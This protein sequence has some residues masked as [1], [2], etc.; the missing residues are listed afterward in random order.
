MLSVIIVED[1]PN[2]ANLISKLIDWPSM[3]ME[4]VAMCQ[5][6]IQA[7]DRIQ[8]LEPDIVITDIRMAG[9]DGIELIRE[10]R[11][12]NIPCDFIIISGYS[13]FDYA[14]SAIR[15]NVEDYLLKPINKGELTA[16]LQ[17]I[18]D[19]RTSANE[20]SNRNSQ[21]IRTL[22]DAF[23]K[24]L[25]ST[26]NPNQVVSVA[27]N[28]GL[29]VQTGMAQC[30]IL[31]IDSES[32]YLPPSL[33]DAII[34]KSRQHLDP[35]CHEM[36]PYIKDA[37]HI[38]LLSN[39]RQE[40]DWNT[41]QQNLFD[42]LLALVQQSGHA[43]LSLTCGV[44][45]PTDTDR[46]TDALQTARFALHYRLQEGSNK[47]YIYNTLK[48]S[49][50]IV[51]DI[52]T[53]QILTDLDRYA[54]TLTFTQLGPL[55]DKIFAHITVG[56]SPAVLLSV[57]ATLTQRILDAVLAIAPTLNK[58][59]LEDEVHTVIHDCANL[60]QMKLSLYAWCKE[61]IE[62][63]SDEKS[64]LGSRPIFEAKQYIDAHFAESISLEE[65]ADHVHLS[66]AYFSVIFK[67]EAGQNFSDYLALR[68]IQTAKQLL[69][70]S[71][72]SVAAVGEAVGYQDNRYFSRIFSKLVGVKPSQYRKLS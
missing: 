45:M 14:Q 24:I 41:V 1:E 58:V 61:T 40:L 70:T 33:P 48:F 43:D 12:L 56:I 72:L 9:M 60:S 15:F 66:P 19:K 63:A 65:L 25:T 30:T 62:T 23:M 39:Y 8:A 32:G 17:R 28:Y 47:L 35:V 4:L 54:E 44:G 57:C 51:R 36:L 49:P 26:E 31:R 3:D 16:S 20:E 11:G 22:R 34:A 27:E 67:K 13:Q 59:Q 21:H 7:L 42:D 38:V 64:K 10:T 71:D 5:D 18:A 52:L 53:P 37:H 29:N 46:L 50:L 69:R 6:G 2:I 68:R 55:L